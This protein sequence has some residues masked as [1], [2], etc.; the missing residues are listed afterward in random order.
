VQIE[1]AKLQEWIRHRG[2]KVVV[3]FDWRDAAGKGGA[4]K[5]ITESLNPP[6]LPIG[7]PGYSNRA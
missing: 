6:R 3:L 7:C 1:L 5:R 4:I 2:L